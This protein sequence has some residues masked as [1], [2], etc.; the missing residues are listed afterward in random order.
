MTD[1]HV[2]V[3]WADHDT[4]RLCWYVNT[5]RGDVVSSEPVSRACDRLATGCD[6][7]STI[8]TALPYL[9]SLPPRLYYHSILPVGRD[10]QTMTFRV[11]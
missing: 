1:G 9:P 8:L 7:N 11:K 5:A 10:I 4:D 6:R 2:F 3:M